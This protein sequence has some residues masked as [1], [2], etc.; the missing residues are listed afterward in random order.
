MGNRGRVR[1]ADD[2][3]S[4]EFYATLLTSLPVLTDA[5]KKFYIRKPAELKKKLVALKRGTTPVSD[6]VREWEEFWRKYGVEADLSAVVGNTTDRKELDRAIFVPTELGDK[7]LN[8]VFEICKAKFPSWRSHEDLD[9]AIPTND[10]DPR[11]G[12]YAILCRN[13]QE[14]DEELKSLS[15]QDL[16]EQKISTMTALER[17]IFEL[18]WFDET[19]DHLDKVNVTLCAGS[20]SSDGSVPCARWCGSKFYVYASYYDVRNAHPRLRGRQVVS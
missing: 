9:A 17:V 8:R 4:R 16:T 3:M 12:S 7:P 2:R 20:R 10:R 6:I 13:R 11:N 15:A 19:G 18:K 5:E 1:S 14:A